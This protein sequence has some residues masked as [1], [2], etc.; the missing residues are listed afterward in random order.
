MS[1]S[2]KLL[3]MAGDARRQRRA[4][5]VAEVVA[6]VGAAEAH[7][8]TSAED[9]WY[10][11]E[12][13]CEGRPGAP[14]VGEFFA[15]EVAAVLGVSP[16]SAFHKLHAAL[17]VK[18]RHPFL[19]EQFLAGEWWWSDVTEI[20]QA[21]R[22]LS[23]EAALRV[24]RMVA[25]AAAVMPIGEIRTRLKGFI[26]EA[27]PEHA[28]A[29]REYWRAYRG[30]E[31]GAFEEGVSRIEGTLDERDA[32]DLDA[33][34]DALAERLP[35]PELPGELE[36]FYQPVG[37]AR[38]R[39]QIRRSQALGEL[40]RGAFG[41]DVLP[42]HELIVHIDASDP[43]LDPDSDGS[44]AAR[45]ERWGAMLTEQ[46]PAFLKDSKVVV[47][48]VVDPRMM[49]VED[50]YRPSEQL[51]FA[52]EQCQPF[53]VFPYGTRRAS[54]CDLDHTVPFVE[55]HAGQTSLDNLGPL[56]RRVHR[57]KTHGGFHL[58]QPEPGV[59][60]WETPHGWRFEVS[61]A[62]T[63]MLAEPPRAVGEP[64]PP[65]DWLDPYADPPQTVPDEPPPMDAQLLPIL[66]RELYQPGLWA[67]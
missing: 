12:H 24:D 52:M 45:V 64:E 20:E 28:R 50:Q 35:E 26:A 18:H 63:R 36:E 41:Q 47:R 38:L 17:S 30:V 8:L 5:A 27:D 43:A 51:R 61:L 6:L 49:P 54:E 16:A 33:A 56:S 65:P 21:C 14:E 4:A 10:G 22:T 40:A 37:L 67:A 53:E 31:I 3:Q 15:L 29:Q 2:V 57:A 66:E 19:W 42:T 55:G 46:L 11:V 32:V 1:E 58:T 25:H 9:A 44:G 34:L 60:Q 48:P 62:G 23:Q 13:Y 7:Q 59:Y 39:R